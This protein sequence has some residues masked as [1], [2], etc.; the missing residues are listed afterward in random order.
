MISF[1]T[2]FKIAL[3]FSGSKANKIQ[4]VPAEIL[5]NLAIEIAYIEAIS[6]SDTY[7]VFGSDFR[8]GAY[9]TSDE[10]TMSLYRPNSNYLVHELGHA[11][12]NIYSSQDINSGKFASTFGR[13]K[14]K[15]DELVTRYEAKGNKR[16]DANEPPKFSLFSRTDNYMTYNELEGFAICF[17]AMMGCEDSQTRFLFKEMPELMDYAVEHYRQIRALKQEYRFKN[18][19]EMQDDN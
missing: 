9:Y 18:L 13:F 15:Y 1:S 2:D 16:F 19:S 14:T 6:K 17:Q 3:D 4:E 5:E 8:A 7:T 12:D 11:I 10:E